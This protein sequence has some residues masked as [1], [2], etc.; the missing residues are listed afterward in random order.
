MRSAIGRYVSLVCIA[1]VFA[2]AILYL[3]QPDFSVEF[4]RAALTFGLIGV[5]AEILS[6]RTGRESSGSLAFIPVLAIAAIAPHWVGVVAVGGSALA[7]QV[8]AKKSLLK[9][10]FNVGQAC[11]AIALAILAYRSLGGVP[12]RGIEESGSLS[13]IALFLVF[14]VTN[15]ICVSGALGIVGERSAWT[16]WKENTLKSLPYD[17]LSLP[18]ILFLSGRIRNMGL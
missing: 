17:F 8:F 16:I 11:F 2:G 6:Y 13:L 1:A 14:F 3:R 12:L 9:T 5:L 18:V 7:A 4:A 10:I 15:S